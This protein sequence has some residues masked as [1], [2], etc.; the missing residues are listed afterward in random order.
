M[1]TRRKSLPAPSVTLLLI[2]CAAFTS[3]GALS[4]TPRVTPQA[5]ARGE[6]A[7][8]G[9]AVLRVQVVDKKGRYVDDARAED[10]RVREDGA[11][12]KIELFSKEEAPV[13]YGVIVDNSGSMRK[14][15]ELVGRA[16]VSIIDANRAGDETFVV[17]F[18]GGD[19]IQ[20][21]ADFT[22]SREEL[23]DAFGEMY[24]EGGE[25][26]LFDAVYAAVERAAEHRKGEPNRARAVVLVTDG[27]ERR[28]VRKREELI[29]LLR[30]AGVKVFPVG[31]IYT[32]EDERGFIKSSP[33]DR[34]VDLLNS[35]AEASGGRAFYP[36]TTQELQQVVAEIGRGLRSHYALGYRPTNAA[37]DGKFRKVKIEMADAPGRAERKALAPAGYF[38]RKPAAA[39]SE[40]K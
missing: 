11:E 1:F 30:G 40:K 26:A 12:Q 15:L 35:F 18:V 25:T 29:E 4:L 32:L 36:K 21:L 7:A 14:M 28:S 23:A 20:T 33:R 16:G 37:R 34:A 24:A 27:E 31:L 39:P 3:G 5:A 19:K 8:E 13:S 6:V 22:A 17:R 2:C 9:L 10:F 38:A